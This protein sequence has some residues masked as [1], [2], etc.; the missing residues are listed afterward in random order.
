MITKMH[1]ITCQGKQSHI[2]ATPSW[3]RQRHDHR[4]DILNNSTTKIR[5]NVYTNMTST[6]IYFKLNNK[7]IQYIQ[8]EQTHILSFHTMK[9]DKKIRK[10]KTRIQPKHTRTRTSSR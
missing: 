3:R 7:A 6:Q 10:L 2:A 9:N 8:E 5:I 1:Q 4:L